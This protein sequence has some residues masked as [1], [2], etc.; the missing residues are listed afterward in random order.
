MADLKV[1]GAELKKLVKLGKKRALS[2]GFCPGAKNEHTLLIDRRKS[3]EMLG[4]LARQE[5][6]SPKVAFGTFE[7]KGRTMEMTCGRTVPQ[8]A[9]VLKKYLKSQKTLVNVVILD[10]DGNT[11]DSDVEDL[12]PDPTMEDAEAPAAAGAEPAAEPAAAAPEADG[13]AEA[14]APADTE[15]GGDGAGD[16]AALAARL[17]ALQPAI[18]AAE[19]AAADKLKQVMAAAIG[20]VKSAALEQAD[21]TITALENAVAKLSAAASAAPAE[22]AADAPDLRALAA[23]AASL[24]EAIAELAAPARDKLMTALASAAQQIKDRNHEAAETMLG[25]IEAAVNKVMAT[26]EAAP[27]TDPDAAKWQAAQARLQPAVDKAMQDKRGDL[28][29]IN[30]NF[31]A[32]KDYAKAGNFAGALH[33]AG[34]T[35]QLLKQASEAETTAAAQ[36]AADSV[37]EGL[38]ALRVAWIETRMGMRKDIERLKAEIDKVT[39]NVE[40]LEDVPSKSGVLFE[41][42]E[43]IDKDLENTLQKMNEAPDADSRNKLKSDAQRIIDTYK[44]VLDTEFFKAV[45]DNGFIKTNIRGSALDSLNKVSSALA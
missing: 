41:Y 23:R 4:K 20:Q 12:P 24:K 36:E 34:K 39:A 22:T 11:L 2:F 31:D 5:G 14:P 9:K 25:K 15:T 1:E 40:G 17:K 27:A 21:Q 28:A 44:G 32:A 29:A 7:V 26:T 13:E 3:P 45:D 18:L 33:A 16:A 6:S 35:A 37:Q 10:A 8:M 43:E 30:M 42:I 19:G 38:V